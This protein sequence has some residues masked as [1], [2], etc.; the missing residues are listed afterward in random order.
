MINKDVLLKI[1]FKIADVIEEN[2]E[3]LSDLDRAI[4]DADHGI[5]MNKGFKKV[6]EKIE[7]VKD[8][9]CG[10][11]LKTVA[12]TLISTVGG[13][14]G[15]LYGTAFLKASMVVNG[16]MEINENDAISMFDQG[17]QGIISRGKAKKGEKTMLDALIPAFEAFKS[18][19]E[20][21]EAMKEAFNEAQLSAKEGVEYTK[22]IIATKGRASYLGERSK[23]HQDPGATS[24]YLILK[25]VAD[26]LNNT[27]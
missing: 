13:A 26:V 25:A 11:I 27:Q 8:K 23:G 4:G 20:E 5:N 1:L 10:T 6:R 22:G 12:M 2:R 18:A 21:G 7:T 17:I 9:D 3:Y 19:I 14:S 15:P 24:S 16:K